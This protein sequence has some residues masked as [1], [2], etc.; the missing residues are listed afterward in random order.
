MN[1]APRLAALAAAALCL[2]VRAA[3]RDFSALQPDEATDRWLLEKSPAYAALIQDIR[4]HGDARGYRFVTTNAVARGMAAWSDGYLEIQLNPALQGADRITTL[5]FEVAN[6]AR[7]RE[8]Q[9][10][11]LAADQGLIATREEFGLANELL[12]YEA[13]RLHRQVLIEL[14]AAAGPLPA[15]FFYFVT[16]APASI[17]EYRLPDLYAYLKTQR[18]TGHTAHYDACFERRKQSKAAS[19]P[20]GRATK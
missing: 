15:A 14:D 13:L 18:E 1:A 6:A 2:A 17:R 16:P 8:H 11:D 19:A 20:Q 7:F 3:A 4:S 5:I 9:Q 10:I 12:E